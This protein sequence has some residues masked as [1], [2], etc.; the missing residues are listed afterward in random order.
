MGNRKNTSTNEP[1]HSKLIIPR[2]DFKRQLK[3]R[4]YIGA[5]LVNS[6]V[7]TVLD[8]GTLEREFTKWDSFNS[9][10]LKTSFDNPNNEYKSEYDINY[11]GYINLGPIDYQKEYKDLLNKIDNKNRKLEQ[12]IEQTELLQVSS[13]N[14]TIGIEASSKTGDMSKVFIVH[15][16]D[17][18][19]KITVARTVEQLGLKAIILHEVANEGRT[20]I[21]K[22]ESITSDIGFAIVIL[23]GD[24]LG[25][26]K[27]ENESDY[28][29][30]ARQNVIFELGYFIGRL[31]R[32]KVAPLYEEGVELPND[33]SGILYTKIDSVGAWKY[34]LGKELK[35]A[36][37]KVDLNKL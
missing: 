34:E 10:L 8:L 20:I 36:G 5:Q 4:L 15:G 18:L 33:L 13:Q 14:N 19:T 31:G 23:S 2:D 7:S 22:F 21:E 11:F 29:P 17:S 1:K 37:Y 28:K 30:R 32:S 12:L 25:K 24:D 27:G 6:K 35:N 9:E 26:A 3:D 16:H